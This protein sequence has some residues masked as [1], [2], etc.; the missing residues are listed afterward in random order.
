MFDQM[1][2]EMVH[3]V[4][5]EDLK[6]YLDSLGI[7]G[8]FERGEL[9]CKFCGNAIT[10]ENLHSLFPESGSIK[11]VCDALGCIDELYNLLRKGVVS[12]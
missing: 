4:H 11:L 10:F 7:L 5:D 9:K 3:A 1:Q 6:H 8:K 12:L 2:K